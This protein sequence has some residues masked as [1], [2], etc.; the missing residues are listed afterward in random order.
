MSGVYSS[1]NN[2]LL[3]K[4]TQYM[5]LDVDLAGRAATFRLLIFLSLESHL[6]AHLDHGAFTKQYVQYDREN[7]NG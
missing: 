1:S 6:C 2:V 3:R 4:H 7:F 5:L